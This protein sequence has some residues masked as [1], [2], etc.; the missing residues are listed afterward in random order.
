MVK[1]N[2]EKL[3]Q[4]AERYLKS[5][6]PGR[7]EPHLRK[8]V[9][10]LPGNPIFHFNYGLCLLQAGKIKKAIDVLQKTITLDNPKPPF[11][12]ALAEA[13]LAGGD[14]GLAINSLEKGITRSPLEVT[15]HQRK[16][17]LLQNTDQWS[18]AVSA[19][20]TVL[21]L[22]AQNVDAFVNSAICKRQL[23]DFSGALEHIN[24]A[25]RFRPETSSI[26]DIKGSIEQNIGNTQRAQDYYQRA[27]E[28]DP[29]NY[30]ARRNSMFN[31]LNL[32][33]IDRTARFQP[34]QA[35]DSQIGATGLGVT[36]FND[37]MFQPDRALK[38]G[39]VSSDFRLH[40]VA[41][42]LLPYFQHLD[43][44][45]FQ[46][47]LFS[48]VKNPDNITAQ[49][50]SLAHAWHETSHLNDD[51]T[52]ALIRKHKIDILIFLAGRFDNNRPSVAAHRAAPV[53][54]SFHDCATS[55]LAEMDYWLTDTYLHPADT[56]EA[57]TE[58]L[59]HLP[60]Y[61]QFTLLDNLPDAGPPPCEEAGH[62]TFG[63][64]NKP[65]KIN[66]QTV[67][68]WA[69]ILKNVPASVIYLKYF[70]FYDDPM[71]R[72]RLIHLFKEQG[73]SEDRLQFGAGYD[74][75]GSH[76]QLYT[77]TDIML[78]PFPFNGATT[79][80]ES[81]CMG[82]PVV[83][84]WGDTFVSRVAGSLLSHIGEAGLAAHSLDEY[85]DIATAL[86]RDPQR[87]NRLRATLR[88]QIIASPLLDPAT[89]AQE[90][91]KAFREMWRRRCRQKSAEAG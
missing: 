68:V 63:V 75:R 84:L 72:G 83:A 71:V 34:A 22:D 81:I 69:K 57:S 18:E 73:V 51:Q 56:Q 13:A 76:L 89:Y 88:R 59:W 15:L 1:T 45:K 79:T 14:I 26:F 61:Y 74:T 41:F 50:R 31:L 62:V 55:G 53:Q 90:I 91:E 36:F 86:A 7:A 9:Q 85:V 30:S 78:D 16:A 29:G 40:V 47:H 38:I 24:T 17:M 27:V 25:G 10:A 8:L 80:F 54:V 19:Y 35:M 70:N 58:E 3:W 5:N 33:H 37:R 20:S 42:N 39:Y 32:S 52:A 48:D 66:A 6:R 65:E 4:T 43:H 23:G 49:F 2:P 77:R 12:S 46:I 87:L 21:A 82:L 11:F 64:F 67:G 60:V 28:L 44:K